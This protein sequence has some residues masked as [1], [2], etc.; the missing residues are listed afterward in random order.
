MAELKR[1]FTEK[2]PEAIGPYCTAA[3]A[4]GMVFCSGVIPVDPATGKLVE[5]GITEQTARVLESVKLIAGELG[6]SLSDAVKTTVFLA[7][8]GD[9]AAMNTLYKDAF[10]EGYP[11]RSC[12]AV[13][14]L[15]MGAKVEIEVVYAEK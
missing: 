12:V 4:R 13:A 8:M 2:G 1:L 10:T 5:G 7:D 11:A 15:P 14:G 3:R 9:F 6:V